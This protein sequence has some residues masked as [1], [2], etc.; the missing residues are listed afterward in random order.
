MKGNGL[1]QTPRRTLSRLPRFLY[2]AGGSTSASGKSV[3]RAVP[4]TDVHSAG[5]VVICGNKGRSEVLLAGN[6]GGCRSSVDEEP[7]S[8]LAS[9]TDV[10]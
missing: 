8:V 7:V 2:A 9:E 4:I 5:S 6:G 3:V 1:T 10:L